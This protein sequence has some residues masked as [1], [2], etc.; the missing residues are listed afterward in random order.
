MAERVR[1]RAPALRSAVPANT[2]KPC[3]SCRA[4]ARLRKRWL[5]QHQ[6]Q[7]YRRHRSL[8]GAR[9]LPHCFVPVGITCSLWDARVREHISR[10]H[11]QT[12]WELSSFSEAA[13]AV[14]QPKSMPAVPPPSQPRRGSTAPTLFW[15]RWHNVF[16]VGR[17]RSRTQIPQTPTNPVGAVEPQRG[18]ESGGSANIHA[19]STTAIAASPGLDSSHIDLPP[20]FQNRR[21]APVVSQRSRSPV[22]LR[23][24]TRSTST[25]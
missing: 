13:K 3:G 7:Q 15:A 1:Y 18:C 10:K 20:V 11:R 14:A 5:S 24:T 12:L 16:A 19:S 9:Q 2:D 21:V 4:P 8:A 23:P 17:P 22:R 6:C 25:C